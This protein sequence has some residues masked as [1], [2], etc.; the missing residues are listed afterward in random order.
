MHLDNIVKLF[1]G[2]RFLFMVRDGRQVVESLRNFVNPVEHERACAMWRDFMTAGLRFSRSSRGDQMLFV[3]YADAVDDTEAELR[4]VFEFLGEPFEQA[5]VEFIR[6]RGPINSSFADGGEGQGTQRRWVA[7]P[8]EERETF[9]EIAG[10]M[11]VEMGFERDHSWVD[12]PVGTTA[13]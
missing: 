3:S 7:W 10:D 6:S 2:A 1:P 13:G 12:A 4:R 5:S 8:R 9:V 11:L